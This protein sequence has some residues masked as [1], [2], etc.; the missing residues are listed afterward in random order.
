MKNKTNVIL[1]SIFIIIALI[2]LARVLLITGNINGL[3]TREKLINPADEC[4]GYNLQ[5][6]AYCLNN[7][8]K[9]IYKYKY[10]YWGIITE[11]ELLREGGDCKTYSNYY[12]LLIKDLNNKQQEKFKSWNVVL[13]THRFIVVSNNEGYCVL[14]QDYYQCFIFEQ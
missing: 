13:D 8:V 2:T 3:I 9:S 4:V 6:T 7:H 10:S 5:M 1:L 14:D 12:T 11:K